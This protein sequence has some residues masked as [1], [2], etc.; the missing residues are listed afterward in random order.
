VGR[1][2]ALYLAFLVL[3]SDLSLF[4]PSCTDSASFMPSPSS[5][6]INSSYRFDLSSV[7]AGRA[8]RHPSYTNSPGTGCFRAA[9]RGLALGPVPEY[10]TRMCWI[11]AL[12]AKAKFLKTTCPKGHAST[13]YETKFNNALYLAYPLHHARSEIERD[14]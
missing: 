9:L 3:F 4:S 10:L 14:R 12:S 2:Q 1:E 8:S 6:C 11:D 5:R 13:D 7:L